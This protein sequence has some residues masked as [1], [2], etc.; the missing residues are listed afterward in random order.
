MLAGCPSWLGS[1]SNYTCT[2]VLRAGT[3]VPVCCTCWD[4]GTMAGACFCHV[5]VVPCFEHVLAGL[6]A[7]RMLRL[8]SAH[9]AC[10]RGEVA[11]TRWMCSSW[12]FLLV[13]PGCDGAAVQHMVVLQTRLMQRNN[14]GASKQGV[15]LWTVAAA[16][17]CLLVVGHHM[18]HL[19]KSPSCHSAW[20][21]Y[22]RQ[23]LC[24]LRVVLCWQPLGGWGDV[25]TRAGG[26]SVAPCYHSSSTW[27]PG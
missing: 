7:P 12:G 8:L 10:C 27:P 21:W 13:Q 23:P 25:R 17:W 14:A 6:F 11:D 20:L 5:A 22:V 15:E 18:G 26:A 4:I 19:G 2:C 24:I 16:Y 9:S 1:V 3:W